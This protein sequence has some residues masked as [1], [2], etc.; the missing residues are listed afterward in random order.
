MADDPH[1]R[2]SGALEP[3]R[4]PDGTMA[5]LP[6]L[7]VAMDF[8]RSDRVATLPAPGADGIAILQALSYSSQDAQ[9]LAG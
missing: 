4:L 7:P 5:A 6:V 9:A 3:V 2:A 1:L 8:A